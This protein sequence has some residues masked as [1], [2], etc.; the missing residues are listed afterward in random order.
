MGIRTVAKPQPPIG[1]TPLVGG[2]GA[3]GTSLE[4]ALHEVSHYFRI[5]H[6]PLTNQESVQQCACSRSNANDCIFSS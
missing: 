6:S 5:C 3:G 2:I 4:G 1:T